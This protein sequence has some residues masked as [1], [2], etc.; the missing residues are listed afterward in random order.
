M[1]TTRLAALLCL[2]SACARPQAQPDRP[3][4]VRAV[5]LEGVT[6]FD[7]A[8][9]LSY[10]HLQ[11]TGR[12]PW[13]EAR[14][15]DEA[16]ARIDA[17][18]ITRLYAAEGHHQARVHALEIAPIEGHAED[19]R[20]II[21][22][23]EGPRATLSAV[24]IKWRDDA[25]VSEAARA[26][27]IEALG[28]KV[29]APLRLADLNAAAPAARAA[30]QAHGHPLAE[31]EV[32]AELDR[33]A[34]IAEAR[35][36]IAPGR[37]ARLGPIRISGLRALPEAPLLAAVQAQ[38]GRDY[39][40]AA[41]QRVEAA[42]YNLDVLQAVTAQLDEVIAPD[43]RVGL[44]A[45]VREAQI[46]SLKLGVGLGF[47]PTRWEERLTALYTHR[48]LLGDLTRL[49][50]R[51]RLGYAQ[52]PT[53]WDAQRS[54]PIA[55]LEPTIHKRGWLEPGLVWTW[56]PSYEL[57]LYDGY[58]FHTPQ[59]RS[60]VSRFFFGFTR[61]TL[62]HTVQFFDFFDLSDAFDLN[63][64]ALGQ[65]FRDPYL[66]SYLTLSYRVYLT[67][68]LLK[69]TRGLILGL[70]AD[71]VGGPLGGDF[72]FLRLRPSIRGYLPLSARLTLAARLEIG[73]IHTYGDHPGAPISMRFMLGGADTVRGWGLSRLSPQISACAEGET[74]CRGVPIGGDSM[75]LG[76]LELRLKITG[77]L[78]LAA[79]L[80]GGDVR[81]GEAE[82]DAARW[83]YAAG[84]GVRAETP[85]GR[86]RVDY[87]HRLTDAPE[88]ADEPRWA[89]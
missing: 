8:T 77:P 68:D 64:T 60:T 71:W 55:H 15:Y 5:E 17:R 12:M 81:P 37:R 57:G 51:L 48:D 83:Q 84:G 3:Y 26:A 62:A 1:N 56:T 40:P 41:V 88:Y 6:R 85:I 45:R 66:I 23:E 16:L 74:G 47:E 44:T 20:V 80:D 22:V 79:F 72:D 82:F 50:V 38:E 35:V 87:G 36:E 30:L 86:L 33:A 18:R 53:A 32:R 54:G 27:A 7:K 63:R 78:L 75:A 69:P 31:V 67:D 58:R 42:L 52:L 10:T 43:G 76:N 46:Q 89:F 14:R 61:A 70:D 11:E 39:S 73:E 28:L 21:R 59:L 9:L 24:K 29:G 19:V 13:S 49:D 25:Q 4:V 34:A 65:D 2:L